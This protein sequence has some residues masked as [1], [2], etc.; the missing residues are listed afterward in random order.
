[1]SKLEIYGIIAV[2]LGLAIA[3]AYFKGHH[4]GYVE[5]AHEVQVKFD[6]FVNDTKEAGLKAQQDNLDKE[7][8]YAT[9]IATAN[10]GRTDALQRLQLAQAAANSSRRASANNPTASSASGNVCFSAAAYNAAFK[11]FGADL[12]RFIQDARGFAAEGDRAAIDASAL[13]KAWPQS[14]AK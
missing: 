1:M 5:G 2:V 13:I 9:N 6:Q 7:K 14:P 4:A 8:L 11:Q 10:A 3:G 12:D